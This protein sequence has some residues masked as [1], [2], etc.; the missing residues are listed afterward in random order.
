VPRAATSSDV[1]N[2]IA[3]SRRREILVLLADSERSVGEIV[4]AL[5]LGQPSVS[6]HLKVLREVGLVD[7]RRHGRQ[8]LY[9]TNAEAIRPLHEW[10][11]T[12]ERF[13]RHQ[14]MRVKERA[15]ANAAKGE[16]S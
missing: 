16:K 7:V 15:E 9:R 14:L 4:D 1:F 11:S 3:E 8:M 5:E 12:F 2:A 10:S 6:K 13:W